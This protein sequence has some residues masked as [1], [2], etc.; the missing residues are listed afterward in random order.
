MKRIYLLLLPLLFSQITLFAQDG[1]N[2]VSYSN[3]V[4]QFSDWNVN[5]DAASGFIPSVATSNGFGSFIDNPASVAFFDESYFSFGLLNSRVE[6]QNSYLGNTITSKDD[7]TKLGNLGFSYTL[8]T[9]QGSF[10]I[11][12]GYNLHTSQNRINETNGR[13]SQSTITDH[14]KDPGSDYYDLAFETYAID[15][16]TEDSSFLESIFRIGIDYPGIT[17]DARTTYSTHIGEYS[18]FFGTE[19]QENLYVG[20]SGG[21]TSGTYTYRRDLLELDDRNDYDGN[22]IEGSDID[23]ILVHDEIDADI[24]GF[25]LRAGLIYQ[26]NPNFNIGASYLLPSTFSVTENYYSSI[27]TNLDDGSAPFE[28]DLEGSDYT[29]KFTKPGQLNIGFAAVDLGGLSVST[30]AEFIDYSNLDLDLISGSDLGGF[31]EERVIRQQEAELDSVMANDYNMVINLKAGAK[32]QINNQ[33]ELRGGYAYLPGKSKLFEA[34]KNVFSGGFG[35]KLSESFVLDV[36]AQYTIWDDRSVAYSYFD[37]GAGEFRQETIS[38]S[39]SKFNILAGIK[40][41]F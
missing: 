38:E 15:Y 2:Q 31:D 35:I 24:V 39:N 32:Y 6:Q 26:L 9:E 36:N 29:Y 41:I 1:N 3:L 17:Q 12:G 25:A 33:F 18:F 40:I 28:Y 16:A 4:L 10:V 7:L 37:D 27:E 30:S 23:N 19:F 13:N 8:P 14:F 11:G 34:D 20:F 21:I 5:G 22:F